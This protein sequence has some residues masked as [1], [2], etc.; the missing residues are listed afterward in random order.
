MP[1]EA[2]DESKIIQQDVSKTERGCPDFINHTLIEKVFTCVFKHGGKYIGPNLGVKQILHLDRVIWMERPIKGRHEN[3]QNPNPKKWN[4]NQCTAKHSN[5]QQ[6]VIY[7]NLPVQW[8]E[9]K[10]P[11]II[12]M[13]FIIRRAIDKKQH[14]SAILRKVS[15]KLAVVFDHFGFLRGLWHKNHMKKPRKFPVFTENQCFWT[16][17][18]PSSRS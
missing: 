13:W 17:L 16:L 18:C 5:R 15:A 2:L 12:S 1:K 10:T 9:C 11:W 3:L 7:L 6:C 14:Q 4:G 8:N